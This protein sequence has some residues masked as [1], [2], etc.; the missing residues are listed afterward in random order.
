MFLFHKSKEDETCLFTAAP[1]QGTIKLGLQFQTPSNSHLISAFLK[2][3]T[4]GNLLPSICQLSVM[5]EIS[6]NFPLSWVTKTRNKMHQRVPVY[7][8]LQTNALFLNCTEFKNWGLSNSE[9]RQTADLLLQVRL[10]QSINCLI[11]AAW[12]RKLNWRELVHISPGG[13][14]C[15]WS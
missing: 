10:Q 3:E 5:L 4:Q 15:Q 12:S 7:T 2:T 13:Y 6:L 1:Q 14:H 9:Q 11:N 8:K